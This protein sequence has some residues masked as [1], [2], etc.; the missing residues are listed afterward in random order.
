MP[1]SA[2]SIKYSKVHIRDD[3]DPNIRPPSPDPYLKTAA[4]AAVTEISSQHRAAFKDGFEREYTDIT[5]RFID[6]LP[7]NTTNVSKDLDVVQFTCPMYYVHEENGPAVVSAMR[8]G[9]L[10]SECTVGYRTEDHS[11][12]AGEKY[13]P[14]AGTVVFRP[15]EEIK[16]IE[17]PVCKN[18]HFDPN[19]FF[20]VV[21]ESADGCILSHNLHTCRV[22]ILDDDI[23][24]ANK[25][26]DVVRDGNIHTMGLRMLAAYVWFCIW[27]IPE[28]GWR[29]FWNLFLDQFENVNYLLEIWLQVYLVDVVL[30][31]TNPETRQHLWVHDSRIY[32]ATL[33][34][35]LLIM[36]K[37][38]MSG[39]DYYQVS[40]L[41]CGSKVALHLKV[42]LFRKFLY[43]S[44]LSHSKVSVQE[45]FGAMDD[46][47]HEVVSEGFVV[48]FQLSKQI[49][50][51]GVILFFLCKKRPLS[52]LPMLIYPIAMACVLNMR[53][54]RTI[55]LKDEVR[56]GEISVFSVLR[57]SCEDLDLLK[58]YNR[59]TSVVTMFEKT[60]KD[61]GVPVRAHA[62]YDFNTMLVMPWITNIAIGSFVILGCHFVLT[63]K[64]TV[65]GFLAIIGIYK[66][67]GSLFQGFYEHLKNLYGVVGPLLHLVVL[68]NMS[69]EA[70][71]RL[72]HLSALSS[73]VQAQFAIIDENPP[74]PRKGPSRFDAL[75]LK[76]DKVSV[77]TD[78][79]GPELPNLQCI[80]SSIPQ[81]RMVAIVGSHGTGKFSLLRILRGSAWPKHG[82]VFIPPHLRCI[83]VPR[84]PQV[85][86]SS[87]LLENLTM[88]FG[89]GG[90]S[91]YDKNRLTDICREVG[92]G[93]HGMSM[94]E[95]QM[96]DRDSSNEETDVDKVPWYEQMSQSELLKMAIIRA[97]YNDPEILLFQR[98]IDEMEASHAARIL[99]IFRVIVDHRG[100]ALPEARAHH[101]RPHSVYFT[102]GRD[103]ERAEVAA[104]I[105][106]IVWH[107][108]Q[109][110]FMQ[111][112]G[113]KNTKEKHYTGNKV[114]N[115]WGKEAA[116]LEAD[117]MDEKQRH[118]DTLFEVEVQK[119]ALV[120]LQRENDQMKGNL[121]TARSEVAAW[122][123]E[124]AEEEEDW[125]ANPLGL[126]SSGSTRERLQMLH[127]R[128]VVPPPESSTFVART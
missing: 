35:L 65:G 50:R 104:D 30:D 90:G 14:T 126:S 116:G 71:N 113:G 11:A 75:Q 38:I 115:S 91:G 28:V 55:N 93:D 121:T 32:T 118:K 26:H 111:L 60:V 39:I 97:I 46:E 34:A 25:F 74:T 112:K 106:D 54:L 78:R 36:S 109:D 66:D 40:S 49:V 70:Q 120:M 84:T 18:L 72:A 110:G 57:Q 37:A 117:L 95:S 123:A 99:R 62:M 92:L 44:N 128:L 81:G 48:I 61:S 33:V 124:A 9:S 20:K 4:L 59:R 41:G 105:A 77:S 1:S 119:H 52:A 6:G 8:I 43:Y 127:E 73:E 96:N 125:V 2:R 17:V 68:L 45:L 89:S 102:T 23:F 29:T 5:E 42:L 87:T 56:Q 88:Y 19:L 27:H 13:I 69:T 67:A 7:T 114:V 21:L 51:V 58:E 103:R 82:H 85:S 64:L 16:S 108:S 10:K 100:I 80:S 107:L 12:K 22:M 63:E 122:H 53:Y 31:Y 98:P 83:L 79:G 24:P 3:A 76:L 94:V 15:G 86:R 47:I 101:S